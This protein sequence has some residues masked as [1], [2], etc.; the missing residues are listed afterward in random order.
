MTEVGKKK[1]LSN[2]TN[3]FTHSIIPGLQ[4]SEFV[5]ASISEGVEESMEEAVVDVAK[6][7][8]EGLNALGFKVTDSNKKLNFG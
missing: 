1:F 5:R 2:V 8:T 4:K 7:F 6:A 3:A